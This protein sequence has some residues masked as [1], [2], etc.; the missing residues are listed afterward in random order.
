[1]NVAGF[2]GQNAR[3]DL[4][5]GCLAGAV[6]TNDADDL[7]W[8]D[9]EG[10]IREHNLIGILRA[11]GGSGEAKSG[12]VKWRTPSMRNFLDTASI[13]QSLDGERLM[14]SLHVPDHRIVSD[15]FGCKEA[16]YTMR[17]DY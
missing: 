11:I 17:R 3:E 13:A 16:G 9:V 14:G 5:Q 8:L 7:A 4:K 15:Q 1:M 2:R 6:W 12:E 10:D